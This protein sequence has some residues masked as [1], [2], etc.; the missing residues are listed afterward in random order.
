MRDVVNL[1]GNDDPLNLGCQGH[2]E[3]AQY[4]PAIAR[5]AERSVR[6]V[7]LEKGIVHDSGEDAPNG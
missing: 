5:D 3:R 6:I 4:V 7:R 2:R 1:P